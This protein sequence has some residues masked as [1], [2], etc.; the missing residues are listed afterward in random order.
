MQAAINEE[1]GMSGMTPDKA[2]ALRRPFSPESIGKLPK[3]GVMLDYVGHAAVVDRLL[4]VDPEWSWEPFAVDERGL[5]A[6]DKAGN[7]WIRMTVCGVTRIGVGDGK[8]AKEV[9]SDALRNAA[10]RFGVA[11]DL[12]AKENL[13]EFAQAAHAHRSDSPAPGRAGVEATGGEIPSS[14]P[15]SPMLDMQGKLAKSMFAV[16]GQAGIP[17]DHQ[18]QHIVGII[19]RPITSRKEL[20]DAD[21]K[22]VIEVTQAMIDHP[23]PEDES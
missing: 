19:G 15:E 9:V 2:T 22:M 23:F 7:L 17:D 3:G 11:L 6:L 8:N 16:M 21:A 14:P 13:V 4:A 1:R 18:R 5:P 10:M 12:W 20:T